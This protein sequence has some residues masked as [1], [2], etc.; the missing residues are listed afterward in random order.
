MRSLALRAVAAIVALAVPLFAQSPTT[1]AA[2]D[3]AARV[4]QRYDTVRDFS[5]K[6][7]HSYEGG[8]LRKKVTERGTVQIKK[9]GRMRW[10]YT[11][12]EKKVFVADGAQI[13]SYIPA[14]RQVYVTAMPATDQAT[15]SALFL[16]G[17]GNLTRDFTVSAAELP[18]VPA[19]TSVLKLVP[20]Q[21][22]R[23][24]ETLFL[25]VDPASYQIRVLSAA[26]KQGGRST[27]TF[28]DIKEN[29]GLTDKIFTFRIPRGVEVVRSDS[30]PGPR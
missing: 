27:F 3:L 26:D 20:R 5:A 16:T 9:P 25:A 17:K 15:T 22:E 1:P 13:F 4:Q 11:D 14:D 18:G 12:P 24:Y 6:F 21:T 7:V 19:G 10:E 8:V 28:S 30:T 23:D 2:A 29:T